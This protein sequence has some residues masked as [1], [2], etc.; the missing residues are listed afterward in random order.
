MLPP[1]STPQALTKPIELAARSGGGVD[2]TLF[3]DRQWGRLWVDVLHVATGRRVEVSA[4]RGNALDVYYHPFAYGPRS[5]Q[6][7]PGPDELA[8]AAR[9]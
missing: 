6:A 5:W 9:D 1:M 7:W 3:W 4:G 2:V 8:A